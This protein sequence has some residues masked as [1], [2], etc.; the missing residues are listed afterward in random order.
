[1]TVLDMGEVATT[2]A[3]AALVSSR[4]PS[5]ARHECPASC[6]C[7]TSPGASSPDS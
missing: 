6:D 7:A 5:S 2:S 1:M 3:S 4:S